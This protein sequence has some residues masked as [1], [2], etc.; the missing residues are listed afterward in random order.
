MSDLDYPECIRELYES[1]IIGEEISLALLKEAKSERDAYHIG[2]LLQLE[3]ETKARLRPFLFE[4]GISLDEGAD[5]SGLMELISAYKSMTWQEFAGFLKEPVQGFLSRFEE[6]AAAAPP[7]DR[8]IVESMVDHEAAILEW[9][10]IESESPS[11]DS[12]HAMISQLQYPLRA[13]LE[14]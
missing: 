8:P 13:S 4:H 14:P 12:L 11:E 3:T 7:E 5:A 10:T 6:I 1:E 9:V 2:T